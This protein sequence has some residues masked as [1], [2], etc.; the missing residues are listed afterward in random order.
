MRTSVTRIVRFRASHRYWKPEWSEEEN[1]ARFGKLTHAH[2]HDYT[3]A[4]T[5]TGLLNPAT[6]G[7]VS[8]A[9][10]DRVLDE[11]VRQRFDGQAIHDLPE[12]AGGKQLPTCEAIATE[13]FTRL[14]A[15][16]TA[17]VTLESVQVAESDSLSAT[18]TS[19]Q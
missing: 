13:V 1:R 8:L 15:R 7:V 6:S 16:L 9:D 10:L 14:A 3:C 19:D 4:V 17:G 5:V 12:F 2:P 18:V 11:E